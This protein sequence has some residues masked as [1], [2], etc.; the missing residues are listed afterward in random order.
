M[1][2]L[3][4]FISKVQELGELIEVKGANWEWEIGAATYA[5]AKRPNPPAVLFDEVPGYEPGY[6]VFT[7]PFSTDKRIALA[8]GLPL[9]SRRLE[10][11]RRLRDRM[12]ERVEL[13]PP[14]E[15]GDG[16]I[17]QNVHTGT[18]IDLFEFPTPKWQALDGG[19][20]IGTGDMVVVRDPDEGWVNLSVNRVQIHD[21]S[22]ATIYLAPARHGDVIRKKYWNRGQ[23]CPVAVTCGGDPSLFTVASMSV[24]W[25][26]SEYDYAGWWLK[27]AVEVIKGPATGLP[28]PASAEIAFEGEMVPPEVETRIEG[29][30]PEF[31]GHYSP[32]AREPSVRIK[33][34]MHRDNPIILG[35]LHWLGPG[36][37]CEPMPMLRAARV[38]SKLDEIVPGVKGVWPPVEFKPTATVISLQQRYAGHAKQAAMAAL[39]IESFMEKYTIVV[40][41]DVD[42]SNLSEVLHAIAYRGEPAEFDVVRGWRGAATDPRLPRDKRASR[43]F[44]TSSLVILACRPFHWMKDFPPSVEVTPELDRR[45]REKWPRL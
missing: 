42:P 13:L 4:E 10:I 44:T 43:D 36:V 45:V 14:V 2:D 11:V 31:T 41:D 20:Y 6:R 40:D 38:W 12:R 18:D 21:K 7:V 5:V 33:T 26:V 25:G 1:S 30:F 8:L 19:R 34:I 3:R 24:P 39:S 23:S 15:V 32:Q 17:T 35:V 9:E 37:V 29:P 27:G 28:I 22:T 16:P